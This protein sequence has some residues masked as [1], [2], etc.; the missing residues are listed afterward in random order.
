MLLSASAA[1]V[2]VGVLLLLAAAITIVTLRRMALEPRKK[3]M[4][5]YAI[6]CSVIVKLVFAL[7]GNNYDVSSYCIVS[8]IVE[9]G[10]SVYAETNRYNYGP[11]WAWLV[12][13]FGH[14]ANCNTGEQFH[15]VIAAFLAAVD[16]IIGLVLADAYSWLAAMVFLLSPI[17]LQVSGYFSQFDNLAVLMALL[18]W[19]MI[20]A[21]KARLPAIVGSSALLGVSLVVKHIMFLFPIWLL[22]WKPLGKLRY[23]VLYAGIAYGIFGSAFLPWWFDPASRAGILRNVFGYRSAYGNSLAGR[24]LGLF[25]PVGSFD[26]AIFHWFHIH[27]G[28]QILWMSLMLA[29]GI[30]L[31]RKDKRDLLLFYLMVLYV[32]SPSLEWQYTAIPMIASAVFCMFWECWAFLGAATCALVL[33]ENGFFSPFFCHLFFHVIAKEDMHRVVAVI[34]TLDQTAGRMFLDSSQLCIGALLVNRW[35]DLGNPKAELSRRSKLL[36]AAV[37]I[38]AGCLPMIVTLARNALHFGS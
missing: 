29:A 28:L 18:A 35:L 25:A 34:I 5:A 31:A 24:L 12:A 7:L 6:V 21:G 14:L 8:N 11:I 26:A 20:R 19:L 4:F 38:I 33:T 37:L 9:Q 23:R 17:S 27:S 13:G 32:A 3:R 30:V 22:F 36:R 16:V 1:A 15:V 2:V 10:K